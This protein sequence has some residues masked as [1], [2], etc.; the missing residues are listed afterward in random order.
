MSADPRPSSAPAAAHITP[1]AAASGRAFA[2][3]SSSR[4]SSASTFTQGGGSQPSSRP[5]SRSAQHRLGGF[6][7]AEPERAEGEEEDDEAAYDFRQHDGMPAAA[8]EGAEEAAECAEERR[9]LRS[10]K[11]ARTARDDE[12]EDHEEEEEEADDDDDDDDD[13]DYDSDDVPEEGGPGASAATLPPLGQLWS[14][15]SI[16]TGTRR[17]T[18][19]MAAAAACSS[20][21]VA[22]LEEALWRRPQRRARRASQAACQRRASSDAPGGARRNGPSSGRARASRASA[23]ANGMQVTLCVSAFSIARSFC[24]VAVGGARPRARLS[25]SSGLG[26][27]PS[28]VAERTGYFVFSRSFRQIRTHI[29]CCV[30]RALPLA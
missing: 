20:A 6:A 17:F 28:T 13:D 1:P 7:P 19:S 5:S 4:A 8:A 24:R 9:P 3:R 21:T 26:P 29:F 22:A 11:R 16:L 2:G 23:R 27:D 14:T 12:E 10:G 15:R 30:E 18:A 25:D